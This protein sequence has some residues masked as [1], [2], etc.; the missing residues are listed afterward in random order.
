MFAVWTALA[1]L[2]GAYYW[3]FLQLGSHPSTLEL[4]HP[5]PFRP[6]HTARSGPGREAAKRTL[7]GED[8][9]GIIQGEGKGGIQEE[10]LKQASLPT[11][12]AERS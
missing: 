7:D 11:F 10:A 3:L 12:D 8:R 5:L 6:V 1:V 4:G 9:S 2:G